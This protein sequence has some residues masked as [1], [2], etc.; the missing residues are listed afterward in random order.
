MSTKSARQPPKP[1]AVARIDAGFQRK[2][3]LNIQRAARCDLRAIQHADHTGP[4]DGVAAFLL[5]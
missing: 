4:H 5:G 3:T 2:D 1:V